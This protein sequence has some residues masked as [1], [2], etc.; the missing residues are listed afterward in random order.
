MT[1]SDQPPLFGSGSTSTPAA[2]EAVPLEHRPPLLLDDNIRTEADLIRRLDAGVY[3]LSELYDL[4]EAAGIAGRDGGY[5]NDGFS[6]RVFQRRVRNALQYAKRTGRA[7]RLG[8]A[9]WVIHGTRDHPKRAILV[10][11]AE[12]SQITMALGA[13]AEIARRIE[14]PVDLVL[15]DPPWQL[16][17]GQADDVGQR[18]YARNAGAVLGGYIELDRQH[19]YLEFSR[20][21]ITPAS[22]VL[23]PGGYLAVVTGPQQ[24]A[25]IQIAAE[26][27]AMTFVNRLVVYRPF[28]LRTT[29]RFASS[30]VEVTLM[31]SGPLQHPQRTFHVLPELPKARSG[32]DYPRDW[33]PD[34]PKY[35]R[36][37]RL[38]YPNQLSPA[39]VDRI[40]RA[41]TNP[42]DFVTDFFAGSGTTALVCLL[43]GRRCLTSD[44]N[45]EALR[46]G[47]ARI[48]DVVSQQQ[49]KLDV[50]AGLG[51]GGLGWSR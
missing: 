8:D 22:Q 13:A 28:P 40:V 2:A 14:E 30:H 16:D 29:R 51:L 23:R 10:I 45:P 36:Q 5:D 48:L 20:E 6:Q 27:A 34:V 33:W 38:R 47:M 12:A 37:R 11:M 24:A 44:V 19:S 17:V 41:T 39:L 35:E 1:A 4:V 46:F 32:A 42:G 25:A 7:R 21:W 43:R 3:R 9:A 49:A 31:C 15:C 50:D 18:L 26:E